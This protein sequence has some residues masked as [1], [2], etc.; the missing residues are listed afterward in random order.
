VID[1]DGE[2]AGIMLLETA[3]NL[4]DRRNLDLVLIS[5]NATPPVA[6]LMDYGKYRYDQ[7]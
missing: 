1:A 3:L 2:Q 7:Q 6:K 4:A 5:P